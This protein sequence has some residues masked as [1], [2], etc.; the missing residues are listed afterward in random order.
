MDILRTFVTFHEY[1]EIT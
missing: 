1:M